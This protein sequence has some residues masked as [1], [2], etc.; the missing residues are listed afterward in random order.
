M[1]GSVWWKDL[2]KIGE[3]DNGGVGGE[4]KLLEK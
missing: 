2:M 1:K 3:V 4:G